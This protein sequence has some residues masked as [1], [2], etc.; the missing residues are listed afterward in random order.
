M[1]KSFIIKIW[2]ALLAMLA[3]SIVI[4]EM[5]SQVLGTVLVFGVAALKAFLVLYYYMGLRQEPKYIS[6][7][8]L[9]GVLCMF[10]LFF[11]L[12]PDIIYVYGR[13]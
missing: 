6:Y 7:A 5:H 2:A 13:P 3:I 11:A 8:M 12:V 10:I 9:A 1:T 4:G